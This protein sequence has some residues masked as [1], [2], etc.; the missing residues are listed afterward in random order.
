MLI[1][2]KWSSDPEQF[3]DDWNDRNRMLEVYAYNVF[4]EP[5]T[6]D[7]RCAPHCD[8]VASRVKGERIGVMHCTVNSTDTTSPLHTGDYPDAAIYC[9]GQVRIYDYVDGRLLA[10]RE[11]DDSIWSVGVE[12]LVSV[13][14]WG[15]MGLVARRGVSVRDG[16]YNP[17]THQF[18]PTNPPNP[19]CDY[20]YMPALDP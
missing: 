9:K 13:Y 20:T 7:G 14:T 5:L 2:T 1:K 10:E 8:E 3:P 15:V 6:R 12:R 11:S 4:G 18:T 19:M 17:S 16:S